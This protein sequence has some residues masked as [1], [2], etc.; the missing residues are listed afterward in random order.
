MAA[1]TGNSNQTKVIL[2]A[3]KFVMHLFLN[4]IF[5][6]LVIMLIAK[7]STSAYR[8][9]YQIFGNVTVE[10]GEGRDVEIQIIKGESTKKI[11]AKLE[12]SRIVVNQYSFFIKAKLTKQ[13]IKP[14]VYKVNT[15]MNY[16]QIFQVITDESKRLDKETETKK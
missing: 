12:R 14:G 15:A 5:Y 9:A 10:T 8:F 7:C 4:V 16:D 11:A 13:N 2:N 6:I 1:K 3:T